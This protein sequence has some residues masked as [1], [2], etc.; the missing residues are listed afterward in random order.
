MSEREGIFIEG[1]WV[2]RESPEPKVQEV[3]ATSAPLESMAFFFA[4]FCEPWSKEFMKCR[5]RT[6]DPR[7]CLPEGRKVTRCGLDL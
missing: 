1:L 3:G 7:E 2:E 4:S 5:S 6:F